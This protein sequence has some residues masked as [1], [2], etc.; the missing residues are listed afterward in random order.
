MLLVCTSR[1]KEW[2]AV[3]VWMQFISLGVSTRA[4]VRFFAMWALAGLGR[5]DWAR[6]LGESEDSKFEPGIPDHY[7]AGVCVSIY[8]KQG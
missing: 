8:V 5:E 7:E 3:R 4:I 2:L 1:P 6:D